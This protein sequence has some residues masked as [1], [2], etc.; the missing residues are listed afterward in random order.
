MSLKDEQELKKISVNSP[1]YVRKMPEDW[2][3]I[4]F[5][6]WLANGQAADDQ[7]LMWLSGTGIASMKQQAEILDPPASSASMRRTFINT[8]TGVKSD[9]KTKAGI[10]DVWFSS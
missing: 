5:L 8:E 9:R 4:H 2:L 1:S 6:P 3:S 10:F 7:H